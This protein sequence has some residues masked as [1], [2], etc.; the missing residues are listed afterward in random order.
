MPFLFV[1]C[2]NIATLAHPDA[3]RREHPLHQNPISWT[4]FD[5]ER[6]FKI[7]PMNEQYKPESGRW[8]NATFAL[9]AAVLTYC[10][11]TSMTHL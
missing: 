4:G 1:G 10:G 5:P 9:R 6:P 2:A 7:G 8:R 11:L 3:V